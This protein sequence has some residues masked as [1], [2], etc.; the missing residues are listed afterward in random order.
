MK[1]TYTSVLI[2]FLIF[3]FPKSALASKKRIGFYMSDSICETSMTFRSINHLVILSV[4]INNDIH[5]NLVMDTG[6]RNLVL[7][8]KKFQNRF[9]YEPSR[10]VQFSGLGNGKAIHGKLSLGNKIS[11]GAIQGEGIPVVVVPS[12]NLFQY[13]D[14]VD[15]VI[16]YDLF[17]RFEVE[18]NS[19]THRISFRPALLTNMPEGYTKIPMR[20][21]DSRPILSSSILLNSNNHVC[22]LMIDTGSSLALLLKTTDIEK[23]KMLHRAQPVGRGLNGVVEGYDVTVDRLMIPGYE[24]NS[25]R[26]SIIES[27]WHNYASIG[28]EILKD[29]AVI[30]NYCKEYIGLKKL[31]ESLPG[32]E[33]SSVSLAKLQK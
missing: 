15:G 23:F 18:I 22:D 11:V 8:G 19:M 33:L 17:L 25:L 9:T 2:L 21:D 5:V 31:D 1:T 10:D 26:A 14:D 32:K 6:C 4:T 20:I 24:M 27:S 13:V 28:M 3:T 7:F 29:Y 30:I 16:G 12:K